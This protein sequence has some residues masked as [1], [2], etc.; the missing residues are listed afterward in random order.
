MQTEL[1]VGRVAAI[2]AAIP[3]AARTI[4]TSIAGEIV[5]IA[6]GRG[7]G[8]LGSRLFAI[9]RPTGWRAIEE[10]CAFYLF[11]AQRRVP[12]FIQRGCSADE[13]RNMLWEDT[14]A[15]L[16]T[17]SGG[18]SF[19]QRATFAELWYRRKHQ[20]AACP[21][22]FRKEDEALEGTAILQLYD[23]LAPLGDEIRIEAMAGL[24][25]EALYDAIAS[26]FSPTLTSVGQTS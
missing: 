1:A 22:L 24:E 17:V 5:L 4:S 8:E 12:A 19:E 23:N 18:G 2:P 15:H 21:R 26:A 13:M 25:V 10:V 6:F 3:H 9:D 11:L 7:K 20:Y 14:W 16:A